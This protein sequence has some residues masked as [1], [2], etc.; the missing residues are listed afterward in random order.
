ML[1]K[2]IDV[3]YVLE[4]HSQI[5]DAERYRLLTSEGPRNVLLL[6]T[7]RKSRRKFLKSWL[8]GD[9]FSNWLVYTQLS[10]GGGLCKTCI[11]MQAHLTHGSLANANFVKKPCI[12]FKKFI[13]KALSHRDAAYHREATLA[14]KNFISSMECG[15][16]IY[17][18]IDA[19]RAKRTTEN[20]KILT[21]IVKTVL[22]CASN[23][24]PL[25]GHSADKGN[26]MKLLQFR[27]DAGDE[28]LKKHFTQMA[29]NAK[30]TSPTI[31]NQILGI[32]STMVVEEIV[33]EANESF[34]SVVADESCDISGKEQLSIVLRYTKDDKVNESFTGF[35]AISS[36]SAESI[37]AAILAYLSRIGVDLRKLVGQGYD[38]ASTMAGY[39]SGVQKR[40][41]KKYPRAIFV[42][43]AAHCLNLVINDQSRVSIVRSTCDIIR[44]T[45]RFF[46]ESPKRRS[47]LGVNIPLFSPTRWSQ[48][49]KSIRIFKANFKL[50]LDALALLMRTRAVRHERKLFP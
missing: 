17:T 46:R 22:F 33:A 41:R 10:G 16:D 7:I 29:G 43:C 6:D 15:K 48:K 4:I 1:G 49:Y 36:V 42:H 35:V 9:R 39:V 25:R 34:I 44:E 45:I 5:T 50:I 14:A 19:G 38:G 8:Q 21:S 37:S 18:C 23:N 30:Y 47:S 27:M 32:A 28:A 12:D 26:F 2:T 40:I 13:E 11:L 3:G 31:Q 24:I 20:K